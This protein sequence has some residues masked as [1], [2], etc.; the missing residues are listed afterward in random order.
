MWKCYRCKRLIC[1]PCARG[2]GGW[3]R[4]CVEATAKR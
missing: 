3:C 2:G 1:D 4:E